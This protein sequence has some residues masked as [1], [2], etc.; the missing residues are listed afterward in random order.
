MSD[1]FPGMIAR[2]QQSSNY[3]NYVPIISTHLVDMDTIL[4]EML[5][6]SL[7]FIDELK[8]M[9]GDCPWPIKLSKTRQK[10]IN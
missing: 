10:A 7:S 5:C 1:P 9:R 4:Q 6:G 3:A 2:N 8:K